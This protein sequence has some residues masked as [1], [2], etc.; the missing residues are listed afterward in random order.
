MRDERRRRAMHGQAMSEYLMLVVVVGLLCIPLV[1]TL[2]AAVG[3]YVRAIY[4]SVSRP[5]P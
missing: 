4:Y 1:K 3:G 2:P 5:V